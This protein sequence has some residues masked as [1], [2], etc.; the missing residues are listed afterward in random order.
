MNL[1][2]SFL[3]VC[4]L[5]IGAKIWSYLLLELAA[6]AAASAAKTLNKFEKIATTTINK[7]CGCVV[8]FCKMEIYA[9]LC[10]LAGWLARHGTK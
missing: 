9:S 10:T 8:C 1:I 5:E 2:S 3:C 6:A 4:S 7:G